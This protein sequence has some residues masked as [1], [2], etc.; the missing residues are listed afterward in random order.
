MVDN[1]HDREPEESGQRPPEPGGQ[2]FYGGQKPESL[3]VP[4]QDKPQSPPPTSDDDGD[5]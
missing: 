3:Q 4:R 1:T 2:H 5:D